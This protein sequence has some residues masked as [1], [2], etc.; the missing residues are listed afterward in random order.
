[1]VVERKRLSLARS[2]VTT[3]ETGQKEAQILVRVMLSPSPP[4]LFVLSAPSS[5]R[6]NLFFEFASFQRSFFPTRSILFD[7]HLAC[8]LKGLGEKP[9]GGKPRVF[10]WT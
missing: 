8:E 4:L 6:K 5:S 1:M 7:K 2:C 3:L 9:Y 10:V